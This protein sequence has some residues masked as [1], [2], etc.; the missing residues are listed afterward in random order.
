[1]LAGLPDAVTW[2]LLAVGLSLLLVAFTVLDRR[3]AALGTEASCPSRYFSTSWTP[4]L[5]R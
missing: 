4:L 3:L 5:K 2:V 1:M